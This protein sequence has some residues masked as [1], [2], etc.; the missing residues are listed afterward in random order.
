MPLDYDECEK[1]HE[2]LNRLFDQ[3]IKDRIEE[4]VQRFLPMVDETIK[5]HIESRL[6]SPSSW[7]SPEKGGELTKWIAEQAKSAADYHIRLFGGCSALNEIVGKLWDAGKEKYIA[8]EVSRRLSEIMK[9][10][11]S[12]V[13]SQRG[14]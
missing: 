12:V 8:D 11:S 14:G 9:K 13:P 3:R 1:L 2:E 7:L 6:R 5:S 4:C 10:I